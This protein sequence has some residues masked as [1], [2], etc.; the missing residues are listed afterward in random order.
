M[1][2]IECSK[3]TNSLYHKY[4]ST[5]LRL[6]RC[7]NCNKISDKYVE[8]DKVLLFID[9]ILLKPQAYK[10]LVYNTNLINT[11]VIAK[12]NYKAIIRI[13]ILINLFEV[14]LNWAYEEINFSESNN[15]IILNND[16]VILQYLFFIVKVGLNNAIYHAIIQFIFKFF[17]ICRYDFD[18]IEF[19]KED[20]RDYKIVH[21]NNV[22]QYI[23]Q[24][25]DKIFHYHPNRVI[26]D[27]II[28]L[29]NITKLLPV[30]IIIWPYDLI[31]LRLNMILIKL[32]N[33]YFVYVNLNSCFSDYKFKNEI[34][35]SIVLSNLVSYLVVEVFL[36][37]VVR[38]IIV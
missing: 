14:Y 35:L 36:M 30:F 28:L 3:A 19:D 32:I 17:G 37:R 16:N 20:G 10:H 4:S 6:T 7:S 18:L 8:Y 33:N 12:Q 27:T 13:L 1:I 9:L 15:A 23:D 25:N 24:H 29:S 5:N 34:L 11:T 21:P 26:I 2:C 22:L 38:S 31:T